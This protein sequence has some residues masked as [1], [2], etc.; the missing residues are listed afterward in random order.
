M[1]R[2]YSDELI[3]SLYANE[4][5]HLGADLGKLCVECNLPAAFVGSSL[6]V[7]RM[8]IHAWFRG[9]SKIRAKNA[10]MIDAFISLLRKDKEAG[11]L[12]VA[13]QRA[14]REY[15]SNMVDKPI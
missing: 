1:P 12:P 6:N 10:K 4:G 3:R 8:T 5:K 13:S 9:T 7:S 14:A 2:T 15:L 11:L